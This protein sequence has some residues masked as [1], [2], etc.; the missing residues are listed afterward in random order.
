MSLTIH[1]FPARMAPEIAFEVIQNLKPKSTV[2]DPMVGSGTSLRIAAANG[3]KTFGTDVEPLA[4]LLTSAWNIQLRPN[5][6]LKSAEILIQ[7]AKQLKVVTL[8]WIDEETKLFIDF[9]FAD[10]QKNQLYRLSRCIIAEKDDDL[11]TLFQIA[12]SR[13]IITKDKGA[14]LARD[15]SHAKPHRVKLENDF[16]VY[17]GFLNNIQIIIKRL[18]ASKNKHRIELKQGDARALHYEDKSAD[19]IIT[20]PPYLHA[21]DYFRG[22][23]LSLVWFGYNLGQLRNMRLGS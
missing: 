4:L 15:V 21:V 9:W 6:I 17:E 22:H 5:T 10:Q 11:K 18:D 7:K 2:I 16:D 19:C 14:S 3:F 23:R 1:P 13:C 20:S 8:S 12:L